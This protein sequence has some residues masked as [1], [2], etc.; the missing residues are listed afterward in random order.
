M[1]SA[2]LV[3]V[4]FGKAVIAEILRK[5]SV[6][7]DE[8]LIEVLYDRIY[9]QFVHEIDAIDNGVEIAEKRAYEI[10]TNLSSRVSYFNPPWNDPN[11]NEDVIHS[12]LIIPT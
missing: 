6:P 12:L 4:H 11:P 7:N 9:E 2:G 8:K 5:L 1:S 3:Y 10:T